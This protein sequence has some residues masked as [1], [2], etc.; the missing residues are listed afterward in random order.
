MIRVLLGAGSAA[1]ANGITADVDLLL[2]AGAAGSAGDDFTI[3]LALDE[4]AATGEVFTAGIDESI[5]LSIAGG[6]VTA[7][8]EIAGADET[9]TVTFSSGQA[10]S[11]GLNADV[12]VSLVAG[13]ADGGGAVIT[14]FSHNFTGN[15]ITSLSQRL[16]FTFTVG[17]SDLT[18]IGLGLYQTTA[19]S[20]NVRIHR[21]SNGALI[22]EANIATATNWND[23]AISPVT[24]LA[25]TQYVIS[26]RAGGATRAVPWRL[27]GLVYTTAITGIAYRFGTADTQPTSSTNNTYAFARFEFTQ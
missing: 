13:E 8:V 10:P 22:A 24:L 27:T 7:G 3:N 15:Q 23:V 2:D 12:G 20:E 26:A 18:C 25:N 5:A 14:E 9:V 16:G 11:S 4:G 21:V 17:S 19:A 6:E 1:A